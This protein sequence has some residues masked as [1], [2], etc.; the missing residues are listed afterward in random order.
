[1]EKLLYQSEHKEI[2]LVDNG[3]IIK[4]F[5]DCNNQSV[6]VR[7]KQ[8]GHKN[9][10]VIFDVELLNEGFMVKEQYLG[11]ESLRDV[12]TS[13]T[14][15]EMFPLIYGLLD[16][17]EHLH[18]LKIVHRDLKP[19]NI[20]YY[21][22]RL[23]IN[24][25]DISKPIVSNQSRDT[26]ILGTVGYASPE[27]YGFSSSDERTDIYSLGVIIEELM[28]NSFAFD[29]KVS[30]SLE[31]LVSKCKHIDPEE[32]YQDI[33][34]LRRDFQLADLSKSKYTLPGFRTNNVLTKIMSTAGYIFLFFVMIS[35]ESDTAVTLLDRIEAKFLGSAMIIITWAILTN[36]LDIKSYL[37]LRLRKNKFWGPFLLWFSLLFIAIL[38][39]ALIFQFIG[40][41]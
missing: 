40:M 21:H 22:N 10:C 12:M 31:F 36:Y 8:N 30:N 13:F 37:P 29:G 1:M 17:V 33:K 27:Q 41:L 23:V 2:S 24:D 9:I 6:Y 16:G 3:Y 26:Q 4:K 7:I 32:R 20:F 15:E 38:I 5:F 11:H 14:K 28:Q 18:S 35:F 19:E 34:S 25:F 39:I